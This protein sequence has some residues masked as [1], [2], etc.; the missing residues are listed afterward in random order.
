MGCGH[1]C[2]MGRLQY[3]VLSTN[4]VKTTCI[5]VTKTLERFV[6]SLLTCR[7]SSFMHSHAPRKLNTVQLSCAVI[8]GKYIVDDV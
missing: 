1:G 2:G 6:F 8:L 7:Q 3:G 4:Q 5:F